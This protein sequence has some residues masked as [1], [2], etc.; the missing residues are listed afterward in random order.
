[1]TAVRQEVAVECQLA[2]VFGR[3]GPVTGLGRAVQTL[4]G[5]FIAVRWLTWGFVIVRVWA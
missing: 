2:A 3:L 4:K 5:V 1:M